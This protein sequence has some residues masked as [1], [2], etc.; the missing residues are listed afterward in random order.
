MDTTHTQLRSQLETQLARLVQRV[1][2]IEG[3]LRSSHDD[4]WAE[5]ATEVEN[6]A[7]LEGLDS[8][9]RREVAAIRS[10]LVRL[11]EGTYG[12]CSK[13]AKPIDVRRLKAMPTAT[14]CLA[15]AKSSNDS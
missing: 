4:D 9:G 8:S 10:A 1:E 13:C 12:V 14:T 11:D 7:V 2:K 6:D 3:D 5:R 15:C